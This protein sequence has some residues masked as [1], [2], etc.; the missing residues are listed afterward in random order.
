MYTSQSQPLSL[1]GISIHRAI[2]VRANFDDLWGS[3]GM[4]EDLGFRSYSDELLRRCN[5]S[6]VRLRQASEFCLS[7][8]RKR[9]S[10]E[11]IEPRCW[12][13]AWLQ[14]LAPKH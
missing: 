10:P 1:Q 7:N 13:G 14:A 12:S 4:S 3:H 2:A 8:D 6:H 9:E 5:V 11:Q